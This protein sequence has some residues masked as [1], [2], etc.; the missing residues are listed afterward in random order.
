MVAG[1]EK[2]PR[3]EPARVMRAERERH[4]QAHR[5][6]LSR[7]R[8][9]RTSGR[10]GQLC[11]RT[12]WAAILPGQLG[13]LVDVFKMSPRCGVFLYLPVGRSDFGLPIGTDCSLGQVR[14]Q[15]RTKLSTSLVYPLEMGIGPPR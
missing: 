10:K 11:R 3:S 14:G 7:E 6:M 8:P 15:E 1:K 5:A 13:W 9:A 12:S 4:S 2:K